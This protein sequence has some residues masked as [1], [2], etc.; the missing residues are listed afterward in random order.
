MRDKSGNPIG[1]R[2]DNP[3]LDSRLYEVEFSY[4]EKM[5]LSVNATAE[6]MFAQ[7]DEQ[8][9]CHVIMDETMDP[10]TNGTQVS[11]DYEFLL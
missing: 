11:K 5:S 6:N 1:R 8:V 10:R 9:N 2:H 4:G 3:I 7:V